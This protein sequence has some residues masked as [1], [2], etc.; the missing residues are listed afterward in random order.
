MK[1]ISLPPAKVTAP[2]STKIKKRRPALWVTAH[3]GA[4]NVH[5]L[6]LPI[7]TTAD[8]AKLILKKKFRTITKAILGFPNGSIRELF[9][10]VRTPKIAAS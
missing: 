2:K 3:Y 8:E 6:T 4:G 1:H 10:K 9:Y 5:S 7:T